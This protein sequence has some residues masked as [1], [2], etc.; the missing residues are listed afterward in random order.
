MK[1][2]VIRA[3]G[4]GFVTE[5]VAIAAPIGR[6]V[7]VEVRASGLCR[8]DHSIAT[9]DMGIPMPVVTG[10]E[11]AGVVV[12]VGPG[13]SRVAV[14]DHVAACLIQ[15]CGMCAH[16]LSGRPYQCQGAE[17]LNRGEQQP[18]RLSSG[19]Q[20][21]FQ[22]FGL[23]GFA[24]RALVHE[25][26]L[27]PMP[28]SMPF[29][30]AALLGCGVVTGAGA[31]LNTARVAAGESV[32][33]LGAGGV[34][35]NAI[36]AAKLVGAGRIV[37]VDVRTDALDRAVHFGAT[38]VVDSAK[39]DAVAAVRAALPGGADHVFDFVGTSG[40]ATQGYAMLGVGG[41]FYVIG[42]AGPTASVEVNLLDAVVRQGRVI[43]V[44]TGSTNHLRDIPM[45]IDLYQRGRF[46]LDDLVSHRIAL[47]EIEDAYTK[48]SDPDVVRI[49]ITSF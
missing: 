26:Q 35:L 15:S 9:K 41:G 5:D 22:A 44:N 23:G 21:L 17:R 39:D 2:S 25:N 48:L 14:G 32:V 11:V 49:V 16:C 4:A 43:G 19:G 13:V 46:N 20:P 36:S 10:H 31:V 47:D 27:V 7:L 30:Q 18:P 42:V 1:A 6:E 34:G 3:V 45:Y 28:A 33:V 12:A 24:E 29:A 38:D 40:V 37:A 8:T